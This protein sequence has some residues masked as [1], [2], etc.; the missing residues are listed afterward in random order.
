MTGK[1]QCFSY[2][3]TVDEKSFFEEKNL[4][5]TWKNGKMPFFV[6]ID[7]YR[8]TGTVLYPGTVLVPGRGRRKVENKD[9]DAKFV[10]I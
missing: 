8:T 7:P 4:K 3:Q 9:A 5:K 6:Y 1:M 10:Q 2:L